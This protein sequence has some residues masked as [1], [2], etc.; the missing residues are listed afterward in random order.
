MEE[1][2]FKEMNEEVLNYLKGCKVIAETDRQSME[3]YVA[4][5]TRGDRVLDV[6]DEGFKLLT[7]VDVAT[8]RRV[9]SAD[10]YTKMVTYNKAEGGVRID[11]ILFDNDLI[12]NNALTHYAY[13][14]DFLEQ[15]SVAEE[16]IGVAQWLPDNW[17]ELMTDE[18]KEEIARDWCKDNGEELQDLLSDSDKTDIAYDYIDENASD[19]VDRAYDRLGDYDRREFIKECIDNL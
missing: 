8:L 2:E 3:A 11:C 13:S 7:G 6:D 18:Q 15:F 9:Y 10:N 1:V 16:K 17:K 19:C 4:E 12:C 14:E 5:V